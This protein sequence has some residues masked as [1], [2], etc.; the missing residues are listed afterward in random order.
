VLGCAHVRDKIR[1]GL[2]WLSE[3]IGVKTQEGIRIDL[4]Q[5][6]LARMVGCSRETINREVGALRRRHAVNVRPGNGQRA[7]FIVKPKQLDSVV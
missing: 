1:L 6:Q 2:I 5:A 7:F 4:N 3:K